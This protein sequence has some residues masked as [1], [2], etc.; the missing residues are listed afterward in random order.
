MESTVTLA[1]VLLAE[2]EQT[3]NS[4]RGAIFYF[5]YILRYDTY[6]ACAPAIFLYN[7]QYFTQT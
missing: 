5:T 4:V 2:W 3:V 6:N 1:Y 7:V